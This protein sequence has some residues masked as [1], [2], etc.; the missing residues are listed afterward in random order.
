MRRFKHWTIRESEVFT[1]QA[2]KLSQSV[3][4]LDDALGL[5]TWAVSKNPRAFDEVPGLPDCF[6]AKTLRWKTDKIDIPPLRIF[7]QVINDS[8]TVELCSIGI[9]HEKPA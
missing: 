5:F 2:A 3:R 9:I 4:S 6:I 7:Y 8:E 1:A